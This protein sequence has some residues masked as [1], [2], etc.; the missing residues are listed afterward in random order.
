MKRQ[1][2]AFAAYALVGVATGGR[3]ASE[4]NAIERARTEACQVDLGASSYRCNPFSPRPAIVGIASGLAWPLYWS[5]EAW[6]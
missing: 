2:L 6:S 5:W 3:A 4:W 1:T